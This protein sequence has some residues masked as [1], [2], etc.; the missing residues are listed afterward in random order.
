MTGLVRAGKSRKMDAGARMQNRTSTNQNTLMT[1]IVQGLM[2]GTVFAVPV[3]VWAYN[4]AAPAV[5]P[6]KADPVAAVAKP[7]R[8]A[9][10]RKPMRVKEAQTI[11]ASQMHIRI[12]D[13]RRSPAPAADN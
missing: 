12:D 11:P 13:G 3:A 5:A 8:R 2:L 1:R 10:A 7:A 6:S 4:Q 9:S